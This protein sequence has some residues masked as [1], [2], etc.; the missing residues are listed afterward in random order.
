MLVEMRKAALLILMGTMFQVDF[1]PDM[2]RLW[3]PI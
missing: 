2:E 1:A 3:E